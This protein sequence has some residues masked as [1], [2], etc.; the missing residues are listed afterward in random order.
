MWVA[1]AMQKLLTFFQQKISMYLPYFKIEMLKS[2]LL[3]WTTGPRPFSALC[4]NMS[5]NLRKHTFNMCTKWR[6]NQPVHLCSLTRVFVVHMKKFC[7]LGRPKWP[8][9]WFWSDYSNVQAD[10]NLCW[11]HM[12][13]RTFWLIYFHIYFEK[14]EFIWIRLLS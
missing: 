8:Q 9:W 4:I 3:K 7:I 6:F 10:L 11:V 5:I 2:C 14:R 1:F 13:K 12:F